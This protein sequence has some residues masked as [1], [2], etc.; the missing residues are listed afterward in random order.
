MSDG[1]GDSLMKPVRLSLGVLVVAA[2]IAGAWTLIR[3]P[4]WL[5]GAAEEDEGPEVLPE[6]PVHLG[7]VARATVHR[8]VEGFGTV[9]AEPAQAGKPPASARVASPAVGVLAEVFC[10]QGQVVEKGASLFQLDDRAAKAEEEKAA[11]ALASARA[12]LA[13]LKA[14]PRPEQIRVA[15][16]QVDR[17]RRGVEYSAKKNSRVVKLV[18][19]QLASEKVLQ[20]AE[21]ELLTVQNE[22]AVAGEQVV[23]HKA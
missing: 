9:E 11:A 17:A 19:D 4:D 8:Y 21:L 16:M 20:E 5:R 14:F 13:K 1:K 2:L 7:K 10:I 23:R 18:A 22:L 3:Q 15:E 6:V 12:S